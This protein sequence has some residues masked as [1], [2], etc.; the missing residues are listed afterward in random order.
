MLRIYQTVSV[1]SSVNKPGDSPFTP[2]RLYGSSSPQALPLLENG[3]YGDAFDGTVDG[4]V[5]GGAR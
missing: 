2:P 5:D 4:T 3:G 1:G